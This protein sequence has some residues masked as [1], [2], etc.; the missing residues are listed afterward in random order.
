MSYHAEVRRLQALSRQQR[1]KAGGHVAIHR[2]RSSD[3]D[4][5][6]GGV[7]PSLRRKTILGSV[8]EVPNN[9]ETK[10]NI[11]AEGG[12]G[13][14]M[15]TAGPWLGGFSLLKMIPS[16]HRNDSGKTAETSVG[17]SDVGAIAPEPEVKN[18]SQTGVGVK[19]LLSSSRRMRQSM[20]QKSWAILGSRNSTVPQIRANILE[21]SVS[22]RNE[23]DS[24]STV[25]LKSLSK[26][27]LCD[28]EIVGKNTVLVGA[29]G[30]LLAAHSDVFLAILYSDSTDAGE[31]VN[32]RS[33]R[34]KI[35]I[36]FAGRDAIEGTMHFLATRSLPGKRENETSE[37]NI[38]CLSQ[39][40]LLSR[41]YKIASLTNHAYRTACRLM[42]KTPCLVCACFDECIE[43][44]KLLPP[45]LTP[46]SLHDELKDFVLE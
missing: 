35:E 3:A 36:P 39:I 26:M 41:V 27:C 9:G 33:N 25:I 24:L 28:V 21:H 14:Q 22:E 43:S 45:N 19:R 16:R 20:S 34:R 2:R 7:D 44:T 11:D 30:Y 18:E 15:N 23:V 13:K 6:V 37:S 5:P 42:N 10:N 46:S 12:T 29:P 40:H 38:R 4:A 31:N 17:S 32:L 8:P 1:V